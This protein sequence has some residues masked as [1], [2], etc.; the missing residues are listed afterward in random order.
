MAIRIKTQKD[1][2]VTE[3][4][5]ELPS[6]LN[7]LEYLLKASRGTGRIVATYQLGGVQWINVE[8]RKQIPE[9]VAQKVRELVG[10]QTREFDGH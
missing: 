3:V 4:A 5:I 2:L 1:Y 10:V 7:E 6:D 9:R 8:Q